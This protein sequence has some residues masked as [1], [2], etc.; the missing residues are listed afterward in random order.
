MNFSLKNYPGGVADLAARIRR[1]VGSSPSRRKEIAA[2]IGL[3]VSTLN[4]MLRKL[5]RR[6]RA[7][8]LA[9]KGRSDKGQ[10]RALPEAWAQ[11][12][13]MGLVEGSAQYSRIYRRL[14]T[15]CDRLGIRPP[16]YST[17]RRAISERFR[18]VFSSSGIRR[19]GDFYKA[20]R[21]MR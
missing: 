9:R 18:K 16:S 19:I 13:L 3:S 7:T 8:A 14:V 20:K 12:A 11:A 21:G 2:E 1:A 5:K 15:Q 17:F 4:G 6:N 10:P